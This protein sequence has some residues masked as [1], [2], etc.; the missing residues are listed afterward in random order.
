MDKEVLKFGLALEST[1][2]KQEAVALYCK[3]LR[4]CAMCEGTDLLVYFYGDGFYNRVRGAEDAVK[5]SVIS[6]SLA[7]VWRRICSIKKV[8]AASVTDGV[9][10]RFLL[11]FRSYSRG[12]DGGEY[13]LKAMFSLLSSSQ[14]VN[15]A[16]SAG[17]VSRGLKGV[18]DGVRRGAIELVN[19]CSKPGRTADYILI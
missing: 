3:Y 17:A 4:A 13:E 2:K 1:G 10:A 16:A 8:A 19:G 5:Y 9:L 18:F 6:E 15:V 14:P 11:A 12:Q 7:A